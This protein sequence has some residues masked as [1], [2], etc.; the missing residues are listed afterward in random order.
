[1]AY[2]IRVS[3]VT[4][5]DRLF[6]ER[7]LLV[8]LRVVVCIFLGGLV[9][10]QGRTSVGGKEVA[11]QNV[12]GMDMAGRMLCSSKFH[13]TH[14]DVAAQFMDDVYGDCRNG[15][16]LGS[17]MANIR[18]DYPSRTLQRSWAGFSPAW[19]ASHVRHLCMGLE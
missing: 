12:D 5:D 10:L 16:F 3:S 13:G 19:T 8:A 7:N 14:D 2:R 18:A 17:V 15:L 1:L 4:N 9:A 6:D 11:R